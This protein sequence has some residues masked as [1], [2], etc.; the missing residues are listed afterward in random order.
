MPAAGWAIVAA[1]VMVVKSAR[2]QLQGHRPPEQPASGQAGSDPGG[3]VGDLLRHLGGVA[4][5]HVERL[6][7]GHG[8]GVPLSYDRADVAA[9]GAHHSRTARTTAWAFQA[10]RWRSTN[11]RATTC[12]AV[13]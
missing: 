3:E 12:I 7:G 4:Q 11:S 10:G 5:V 13:G 2:A 9:V 6:L 1:L 8:L